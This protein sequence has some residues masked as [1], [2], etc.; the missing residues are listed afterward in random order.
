MIGLSKRISSLEA[1]GE[2][3]DL[4]Y[5]AKRLQAEGERIADLT[6]GEHD[7][8]T[9]AT[10][11]DAMHRS[12]RGGHTGYPA[13]GGT[14]GFKEAIARR[15]SERTGVAAGPENVLVTPGGQSA[16][17]ASFLAICDPGDSVV[18]V[19]PH[20]ATYPGTIRAAGAVPKTV[21]A[22]PENGFH[23]LAED[24]A[25][26]TSGASA[27]LINTPNNPSGAVY[28][29][30]TLEGVAETC[31]TN[32]LWLI[33]DEVYETQVWEGRHLSPRTLPDM[34]ERTLVVGS[35]SKSHAMTGSRI[36]WIL[37]P[38]KAIEQLA[39]LSIHTT[40]GV[41]GY[42]QDA[43]LFA[44][45][46]GE[47]LEARIAEPFRRRRAIAE[48][49]LA[50]S[51]VAAATPCHGAMYIMLDVRAACDTGIAFARRLLDEERIAAMPGE[52]FGAAAAGHIRVAMTVDD[53][54]FA[55]A[56]A[57]IL[58]FAERIAA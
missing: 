15:A 48:K 3:W 35:M 34:A 12:A 28:D 23:P 52:S 43:A 38:E 13:I 7:I 36:G 25:A 21:L 6:I 5:R 45:E 19:D 18:F 29:L 2:S 26:A 1:D 32:G 39:N 30:P 57:R 49:L 14:K 16:L 56:F 17:F 11:L 27:L 9:D 31:R 40:F 4:F 51:N 44:L 42:I 22:R 37:G 54:I 46:Q 33:S 41:A 10:I 47:E 58:R 50:G 8:G 55:D 20:Y 53:E 24:L